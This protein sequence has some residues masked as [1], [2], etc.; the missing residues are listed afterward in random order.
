[1]Q[2]AGTSF[3]GAY[4]IPIALELRDPTELRSE[5]AL[6]RTVE[7][8]G[9]RVTF[10]RAII[11]PT[12]IAVEAEFDPANSK[13]IFSFADLKLIGDRGEQF[14][15]QST[16]HVDER[17][18]I[19]YFEG[20]SFAIPES[21]T[22]TGSRAR[23]VDKDRLAL[24]VDTD[25]LKVLEAPDDR[26]SLER[27]TDQGEMLELR[28]ILKGIDP[29]DNMLYSVVE[30]AFKDGDGNAY[31]AGNGH[32]YGNNGE[33]GQYV[34]LRIPDKDYAQPLSFRIFN[35]PAYVEEPFEIRI[36]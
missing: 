4:R 12:R 21:L 6:D 18:Q 30:G 10:K 26:I 19:V 8:E 34:T 22:L 11:H 2:R 25:K 20:S 32:T 3:G 27:V 29:D 7:L 36:R 15:L 14:A 9:Q 31:E 17:T 16:T 28:L 1:M 35:Y 24:V 23:A 33:D 13:T 5:Y